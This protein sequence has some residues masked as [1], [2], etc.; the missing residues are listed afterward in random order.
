M[1]T[2]TV[3]AFN[4]PSEAEPLKGRLTAAGIQA[5]IHSESKLDE[6]LDFSRPRAGVRIEV[7]RADFEKALRMV[8]DWNV[9]L[10]PEGAASVAVNR[11]STGVDAPRQSDT[12]RPT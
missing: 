10:N 9:A 7:P 11:G 1:K 12:W 4:S 5:E 8:Y 2:V 6:T 3:A